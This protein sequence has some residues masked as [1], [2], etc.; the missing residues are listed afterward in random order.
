VRTIRKLSFLLLIS[1]TVQQCSNPVFDGAKE[2]L[3][4]L[5]LEKSPYKDLLLQEYPGKG[6]FSLYVQNVGFNPK[7]PDNICYA[8]NDEAVQFLCDAE[9]ACGT[10]SGDARLLCLYDALTVSLKRR[11]EHHERDRHR[12]S[13]NGAVHGKHFSPEAWENVERLYDRLESIV[14]MI[15]HQNGGDDDHK[16]ED[17]DDPDDDDQSNVTLV[18]KIQRFYSELARIKQ[19]Y[20]DSGSV[21]VFV[22]IRSVDVHHPVQGWIQV[23]TEKARVNLA[24]LQLNDILAMDVLEPGNYDGIRLNFGDDNVIRRAE[25]VTASSLLT[26]DDRED[27]HN[28][29]HAE[30][31]HKINLEKIR[32]TVWKSYPLQFQDPANRSVILPDPWAIDAASAT[33]IRFSFNIDR[34]IT[35]DDQGRFFFEPVLNVETI[36]GNSYQD[37]AQPTDL[38]LNNGR[39]RITADAGAFDK[40]LRFSALPIAVQDLPA[41]SPHGEEVLAAYEM[42]PNGVFN[43]GISV[44]IP[45]TPATTIP[46]GKGYFK[47]QYFNEN[48]QMWI[49][50][51]T[52]DVDAA[53]NTVTIHTNHFTVFKFVAQPGFQLSE[54]GEVAGRVQFSALN[55]VL[56][57]LLPNYLPELPIGD[58]VAPSVSETQLD[59]GFANSRITL[60]NIVTRDLGLSI[61]PVAGSSDLVRVQVLAKRPFR[62]AHGNVRLALNLKNKCN[63]NAWDC[64]GACKTWPKDLKLLCDLLCL[65]S[66]IACRNTASQVVDTNLSMTYAYDVTNI[67]LSL[68]YRIVL[69][70]LTKTFRFVYV[71]TGAPAGEWLHLQSTLVSAQGTGSVI[72]GVVGTLASWLQAIAVEVA[73]NS[74]VQSVFKRLLGK[75][76]SI[77]LNIYLVNPALTVDNFYLDNLGI[78]YKL[79]AQKT[80]HADSLPTSFV[81]TTGGCATTPNFPYDLPVTTTLTLPPSVQ[82]G[83]GYPLSAINRIFIDMANNGYLCWN[84]SDATTGSSFTMEPTAPPSILYIGNYT[85][86]VSIPIRTRVSGAGQTTLEQSGVLHFYYRIVTS[87]GSNQIVLVPVKLTYPFT[88]PRIT[89]SLDA[90]NATFVNGKKGIPI[91]VGGILED[92]PIQRSMLRGV[93]LEEEGGILIIGGKVEGVKIDYTGHNRDYEWLWLKDWPTKTAGCGPYM[94]G[95]LTSANTLMLA[96]GRPLRIINHSVDPVLFNAVIGHSV[97]FS[98]RCIGVIGQEKQFSVEN[99]LNDHF[100]TDETNGLL[101]M[102]NY[103]VQVLNDYVTAI[104]LYAVNIKGDSTPELLQIRDESVT[105]PFNAI[106]NGPGPIYFDWYT[107]KSCCAT[108]P[109]DIVKYTVPVPQRHIDEGGIY[110]VSVQKRVGGYDQ[111]L[112]NCTVYNVQMGAGTVQMTPVQD[113]CMNELAG[114]VIDEQANLMWS[115]CSQG[116][117]LYDPACGGSTQ[118]FNNRSAASTSCEQSDL[119]AFTDWRVP[120]QVENMTLQNLANRRSLFPATTGVY[121]SS[122]TFTPLDIHTFTFL[123]WA[124]CIEKWGIGRYIKNTALSTPQKWGVF[125]SYQDDWYDFNTAYYHDRIDA[126]LHLLGFTFGTVPDDP[127]V[128]NQGIPFCGYWFLQKL[129]ITACL[130]DPGRCNLDL[131]ILDKGPGIFAAKKG[132][133]ESYTY[134]GADGSMRG[135][136][137]FVSLSRCA[138]PAMQEP[139]CPYMHHKKV[140]CVRTL[141]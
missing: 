93:H 129:P 69:D 92:S 104:G 2:F 126:A 131:K 56:D 26:H 141:H 60:K 14:R 102:R 61:G 94:S 114:I 5:L 16:S 42:K 36:T 128:A 107:E 10:L 12:E 113:F 116:Q 89:S 66:F 51:P 117:E 72:G 28:E 118:T 122:T 78:A 103:P 127:S 88:D 99:I 54:A 29:S 45:Y 121:W 70:P 47:A 13:H 138:F 135:F 86:R 101:P 53:A 105:D 21:Q 32:R 62:I 132:N 22:D 120:T 7:T 31:E 44:T 91:R 11:R 41:Q 57:K 124:A 50:I 34:S 95:T 23:S 110:R 15:R 74:L 77:M 58:E 79:S 96:N 115:K 64:I 139:F 83:I 136:F 76:V 84:L 106:L 8:N 25:T 27:H 20:N 9:A 33:D 87:V 40:P 43:K 4:S 90:L 46:D 75:F 108:S 19:K 63:S 133:T 49:D 97:S 109:T 130:R 81:G 39:V 123:T 111:L 67:Q 55:Y 119:A 18:Q 65:E 73:N 59:I 71:Q 137:D 17:H 85:S 38:L 37:P 1:L 80:V 125:T 48:K 3:N 52:F 100:Y 140:R 68:I 6:V 24:D 112:I 98:G 35:M 30:K 82:F 134:F